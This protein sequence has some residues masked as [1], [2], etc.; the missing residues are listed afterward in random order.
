MCVV[1]KNKWKRCLL[2][3]LGERGKETRKWF[4]RLS[5]IPLLVKYIFRKGKSQPQSRKL[6]GTVCWAPGWRDN[7]LRQVGRLVWSGRAWFGP[8]LTCLWGWRVFL[9]GQ[10]G[11]NKTSLFSISL[12]SVPL[13]SVCFSL[14]RSPTRLSTENKYLIHR[15]VF[16]NSSP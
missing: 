8:C 14:G 16:F 12:V 11:D 2:Y 4:T 3:F 7:Y 5:I 1:V 10:E 15:R 9:M 6:S 13:T